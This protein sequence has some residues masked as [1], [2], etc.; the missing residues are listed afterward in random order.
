MLYEKSPV[1]FVCLFVCLFVILRHSRENFT[2]M[3]ASAL[4]V[5]NNF[6]LYS[7]FDWWRFFSEPQL[8]WHGTSI[9]N[10]HLR[11]PITVT[12]VAEGLGMELSLHVFTNKVE[13]R[14]RKSSKK[15]PFHPAIN[16]QSAAKR[17]F[18]LDVAFSKNAILFHFLFRHVWQK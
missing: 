2:H 13:A 5:Y 6:N 17:N 16:F 8:M 7:A 3:V 12:L 9:N 18:W 14:S 1:D 10:G 4:P 15:F 11:G